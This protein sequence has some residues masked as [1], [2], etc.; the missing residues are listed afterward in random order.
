[1]AHV[2]G[3]L[4]TVD[5]EGLETREVNRAIKQAIGEGA[6]EIHVLHPAGRHSFA[7]ALKAERP[8]GRLR[9]SGGLVHAPA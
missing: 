1:M 7:V 2:T 5:A 4:A 3:E 6:R 8:E 9:G